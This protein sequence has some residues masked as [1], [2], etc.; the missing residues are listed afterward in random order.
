MNACSDLPAWKWLISHPLSVH[1]RTSLIKSI[2]SDRDQVKMVGNLS[3]DDSQTF[4]DMVYEVNIPRVSRLN[5]KSRISTSGVRPSGF[6]NPHKMFAMFVQD[7]RP[8]RTS[9]QNLED[10]QFI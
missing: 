9:S 1:E 5:G 10:P 6:S 8:P 2:F 7:L 3:G 4:V